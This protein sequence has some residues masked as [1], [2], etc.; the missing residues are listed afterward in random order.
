MNTCQDEVITK[1]NTM[2]SIAC[3]SRL[4]GVLLICLLSFAS[5]AQLP[6]G[7]SSICVTNKNVFTTCD[8]ILCYIVNV[9]NTCNPSTPAYSKIE[10]DTVSVGETYCPVIV[11]SP[12]ESLLFTEVMVIP[13]NGSGVGRERLPAC[14]ETSLSGV[15]CPGSASNC[16]FRII[17]TGVNTYDIYQDCVS[18]TGN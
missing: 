10:C 17:C 7:A 16:H 18:G 9:Q 13:L 5:Y 14:P 2:K 3:F 1:K 12:C 15:R 6:P 11:L 4:P 8:Y